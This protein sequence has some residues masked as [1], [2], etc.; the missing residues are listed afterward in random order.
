MRWT[1]ID[2]KTNF[3][4]T[5]FRTG[6]DE[7]DLCPRKGS[8]PSI[9]STHAADLRS[10]RYVF[11]AGHLIVGAGSSP[12]YTLALTYLDENLPTTLSTKYIGQCP[13]ITTTL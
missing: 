13:D 3:R 11:W 9:C 10:Y 6:V 7:V 5:F 8:D 12:M 4:W 1:A 2:S